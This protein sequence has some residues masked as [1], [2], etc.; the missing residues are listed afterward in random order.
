MWP[1]W[2][3]IPIGDL[4]DVTLA[5]EELMK[6]IMWWKLSSDESYQVMKV[7]KWWNLCNDEMYLMMKVIWWRKL[8]SDESYLMMKVLRS[9]NCKRSDKEWWLVT[10]HLWRCFESLMQIRNKIKKK[11]SEVLP[12][13]LIYF[14]NSNTDLNWWLYE[15]LVSMKKNYF[16][17]W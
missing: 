2:V 9:W 17:I 6:V 7:I 11:T 15:F 8:S 12:Q 4:T 5:I 10:F 3:M 16:F 1:W 14:T 13:K